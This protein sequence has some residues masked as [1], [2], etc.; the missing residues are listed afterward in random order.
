MFLAVPLLRS[1]LVLML[2]LGA[3]GAV[4]ADDEAEQG[5]RI[6]AMS[7]A[8]L[9]RFVE[10]VTAAVGQ[11]SLKM[12]GAAQRRD[13]L[14]LIRIS[15]SFGL[16]Y[17]Y[18]GAALAAP[19]ASA[20]DDAGLGLRA[21]IV[22]GRVL[23]FAARVRAAEWLRPC[24]DFAVPDDRR[25]D[26]RYRQPQPIA[27]GDFAGAVADA[28]EA[29]L[30]NLAAAG[31]A[32]KSGACPAISSAGEAI[33]LYMP[34]LEKLAADISAR[35]EVL[36]PRVSRRLIDN[37]RAQLGAAEQ[38]LWRRF[39][40]ICPHDAGGSGPGGNGATPTPE[41]QTPR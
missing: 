38:A 33:T 13:C 11:D 30:T 22:Q 9:T 17:G 16:G 37:D 26:P 21:R 1:V 35:P 3:A 18:L 5:T 27:S 12:Q 15:N 40:S 29:A 2:L 41:P 10:A 19:P 28:H 34:Y 14:E 8:E 32:I 24:A 39:S 36:G 7:A 23:T 4:R 6:A 20:K 31:A 25:G